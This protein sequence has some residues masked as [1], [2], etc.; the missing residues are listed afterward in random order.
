MGGSVHEAVV[1]CELPPHRAWIEGGDGQSAFTGG[2]CDTQPDGSQSHD[3]EA[4]VGQGLCSAHG[5][6]ANRQHFDQCQALE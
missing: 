6:E 4:I 2:E 1:E 5:V 3:Y